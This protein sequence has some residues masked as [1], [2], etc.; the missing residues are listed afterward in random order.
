ME[1][2]PKYDSAWYN[3]GFVLY[4]LGQK[5]EAK[6]CYEKAREINPKLR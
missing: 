4:D 1:L 2:N 5:E 3:K 6:R